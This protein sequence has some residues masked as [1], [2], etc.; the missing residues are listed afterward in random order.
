MKKLALA[1]LCL[2]LLAAVPAAVR[3]DTLVDWTLS[4]NFSTGERFPALSPWTQQLA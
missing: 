4:G 3:A 2:V 1:L